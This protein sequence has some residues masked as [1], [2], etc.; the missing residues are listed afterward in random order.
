MR[1]ALTSV[2]SLSSDHIQTNTKRIELFEIIRQVHPNLMIL[3]EPY[4]DTASENYA[5][6]LI[7]ASEHFSAL[8]DYVNR[9]SFTQ[10]EER[11]LK[12]FFSND[13][14]DPVVLPDEFRFERLQMASQ[15]LE[16]ASK[17][18][19]KALSLHRYPA[20]FPI[21]HIQNEQREEGHL[22]F[23]FQGTPLLSVIGMQ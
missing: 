10:E 7:N 16:H 17:A 20:E 23:S 12:T 22:V 14:F 6:R 9:L 18:G 5:E 1:D 15:W 3:I 4:A 11:S 8:Y 21:S 19:L 2:H 13:F